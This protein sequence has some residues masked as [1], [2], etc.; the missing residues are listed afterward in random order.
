MK[1]KAL[2]LS[3]TVLIAIL[4]SPAH[5]ISEKYRQQL[6][7]SGCTQLTDGNGCD[8]KKSKAENMKIMSTPDKQELTEFLRD[9]VVDQKTDNAYQALAGYGYEATVP[10]EW[11]K[12]NS[13]I[14]LDIQNDII[15]HA[16]IKPWP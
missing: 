7:H 16:T 8:I 13:V 1:S 9:S 10:G 2:L 3:G 5:A 11:K 6:E 12:G 4:S 14:I 15:K